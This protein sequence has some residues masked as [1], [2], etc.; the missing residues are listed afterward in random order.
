MGFGRGLALFK[1][2]TQQLVS[3]AAAAEP[4]CASLLE[5]ID[6]DLLALF[7]FSS[8]SVPRMLLCRARLFVL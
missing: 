6:A 2:N 3:S 4:L 7:L 8:F 5:C 1:C